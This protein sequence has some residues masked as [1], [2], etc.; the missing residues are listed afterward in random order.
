MTT[1]FLEI[2][3]RKLAVLPVADYERLVELAE[4]TEDIRA[5][6]EAE[7]RLAAGEEEY[8]PAEILDRLLAGESPLK[9]W[10]QY[11]GLGGAELADKVGTTHASISRIENGSQNP[12]AAMWRK[13]A[14]VLKVDIDDII[15][16][17]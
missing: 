4:E 11:R 6:E 3:G 12:P 13:L 16:D 17:G 9:I 5:A 15:P 14:T 7:R 2:A 8:V 1:Q 10:R